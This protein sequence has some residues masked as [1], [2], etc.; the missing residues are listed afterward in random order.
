[1][2]NKSRSVELAVLSVEQAEG[3]GARVRRSIGRSELPNLDPFLLLDEF[4]VPPPGGFPD[5]P[6]RGFETVTYMLSGAF[7]HEDFCGHK[8]IINVGDLQWMTAGKGIMHC[9]MPVAG[10][11]IPHG[12]QLWV[13]LSAKD[14]MIEPSYQELLDKDVPKVDKE[15]IH[16]CVIA[17]ESFGV[18]SPVLTR[19]PTMYLNFTL[20]PN[21]KL[22]QNI[23]EEYNA[24][25]YTLEGTAEYGSNKHKSGPHHT[26]VLGKGLKLEVETKSE[27]ARFVL[28][29]GKPLNEP[30]VSRGPF[31]MNTD[32]EIMQAYMDFQTGKNG[33]E[34]APG[35][36]S[37]TAFGKK[38]K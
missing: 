3:K 4:R 5:H 26:L 18:S 12:L 33:F 23:P 10:D 16:V 21:T 22:S 19:T 20:Q 34:R 15:G 25:V 37:E 36:Q 7:C 27:V 9:E 6:H 17:G 2:D 32:Q 11:E 31:V 29:G 38:N 14:K 30:V 24:F 13:N 1:M 8:G 28:I 35:W